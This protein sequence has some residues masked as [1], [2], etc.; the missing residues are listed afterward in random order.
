MKFPSIKTTVSYMATTL[1][2]FFLIATHVTAD[3]SQAFTDL[4]QNPYTKEIEGLVER[5]II[6]GYPDGSFRP[7]Q[8][9]SRAETAIMFQRAL[10]LPESDQTAPFDDVVGQYFEPKVMATYEAG[11]FRGT[12]ASRFGPEDTLT[13]EQM[14]S[15][16]VRAFGLE[17]VEGVEVPFEDLDE[18][19][20]DHRQDIEILFQNGA[21]TGIT[22]ERYHPRG[23]V[24]RD[25]FS[26]FVY[27]LV[28]DEE[29]EAEGEEAEDEGN[30]EES[31][32]MD[33]EIEN[34]EGGDTGSEEAADPSVATASAV[35]MSDGSTVHATISD[36]PG[37]AIT[38]DLRQY[39]GSVAIQNGTITVNQD[40]YITL[41]I[42]GFNFEE[43]PDN[44]RLDEGQNRL[45]AADVLGSGNRDLSFIRN[46]WGNTVE[47]GGELVNT[48]GDA[49]PLTV[50]FRMN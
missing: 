1:A 26:V 5:E 36:A 6:Q 38:F 14:A 16:I 2:A 4:E 9:V 23:V 7:N 25:Q 37:H 17:P 34:G 35:Q 15:V 49:T 32:D 31:E 21:T 12:S 33:E 30:E 41:S 28:S 19:M 42:R 11:I 22:P 24:P 50:T 46:Y 3:A 29:E 43:L 44:E 45:T 20:A 13:R 48:N 18:A 10:E 27:R 40:S 39:D 47:L 8:E